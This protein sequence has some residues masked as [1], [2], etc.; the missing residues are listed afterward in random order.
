M[1]EYTPNAGQVRNAYGAHMGD[2]HGITK[3]ALNEFDR[4]LAAH[5]AEVRKAAIGEAIRAMAMSRG[6]GQ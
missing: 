5:D 3:D 1:S 6:S 4:W 2:C